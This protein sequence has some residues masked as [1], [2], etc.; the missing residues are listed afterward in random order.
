MLTDTKT[1][2]PTLHFDRDTLSTVLKKIDPA[3]PMESLATLIKAAGGNENDAIQT[4]FGQL[5][6]VVLGGSASVDESDLVS[7]IDGIDASGANG[8]VISLAGTDSAKLAS[9]AGSDIGVRYALI[10][11]LPFA[12]TGNIALYDNLNRDGSLFK[13]DPNSG[14]KLYTDEWLKDRAQ[15][16]AVRF[17]AGGEGTVTVSGTQSWTFEERTEAGNT[18]VQVNADQGQR[19]SN[20]MTFATG[21][22]E[23]QTLVGSSGGDKVYSGSGD[24]NINA[25]AGDDY[26]EGGAGGDMIDGGRGNDTLLGGQGDDQIDG[27]LGNDKL[28]GGAGADYLIGGKGD[29][30]MEGGNGLDSYVIDADDGNDVIVDADGLGEIVFEGQAL[31]GAGAM[32]DGKFVSPDDK[33]S[34]SF[35]GDMEE[36]GVLTIATDTSNIKVVNFKNGQLGISLI[37]LAAN[38]GSPEP[39]GLTGQP[40][41][42]AT[43]PVSAATVAGNLGAT[44][45][46]IEPAP[47]LDGSVAA[48][49]G[50]APDAALGDHASGSSPSESNAAASLDDSAYGELFSDPL[51]SLPMVTGENVYQ[52]INTHHSLTPKT[53]SAAAINTLPAPGNVSFLDPTFMANE[54]ISARHIEYALMDFH[55]A[56]NIGSALGNDNL[57]D[58]FS[59]GVSSLTVGTAF[60]SKQLS[61]DTY[62]DLGSKRIGVKG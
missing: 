3:F 45:G 44:R 35:A 46:T 48:S 15:F 60:D 57:G 9:L 16:L 23:T 28:D 12:V 24:D 11:G 27:S 53:R 1:S 17:N 41:T 61:D 58:S 33:I 50:N 4:L 31:T 13:F 6:K 49:V 5:N 21:T 37:A 19:A 39:L 55:D 42:R 40:F 18:R 20:K 51:A 47:P 56:I 7:L 30:R 62:T 14:E 8:K 26:V 22:T 2:K 29:D 54:G 36:G 32:K 43:R 34:Y 10:H 59:I 38:D 25:G 52:A